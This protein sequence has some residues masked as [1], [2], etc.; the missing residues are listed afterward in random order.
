LQ[1][2]KYEQDQTDLALALENKLLTEEHYLE[3]MRQGRANHEKALTDIEKKAADARLK[4]T[5]AELQSRQATTAQILGNLTVLMNSENRKQFE[6]GK[7][8][9]I[10]N[11]VISTYTGMSKAL[12]LGWPLGPIAAAAIAVKGFAQVQSIR[13]QTFGGGGAGGTAAAGGATLAAGGS[14]AI[15]NTQA[16][17]A[18]SE[19]IQRSTS[20]DIALVG[21]DSRDRA[22]AGSII[23]QIN[24]E[25]ESGGRISRIGLA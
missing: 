10:A 19:E 4:Q 25:I 15:S 14:S 1:L 8:A 16:V 3:L 23:E 21:A 11:S 9:G 12:E 6:I 13:S 18:Q 17:N 22:V 20:I 5:Q 24:Q 7:A 2:A